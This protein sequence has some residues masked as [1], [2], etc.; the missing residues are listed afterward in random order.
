MNAAIAIGLIGVA[1]CAC[2]FAAAIGAA[3]AR[4]LFSLTMFVAAAGALAAAALVALGAGEAGL[5]QALFGL[6]LAPM[7]LLACLLLSTRAAK[8][9]RHGMPWLTI[10]AALGAVGAAIWALP[11]LG[12]IPAPP[13][14][15]MARFDLPL[16][17]SLAALV[18]VAVAGA[19]SLLAYGERGALQRVA[20][21]R[22]E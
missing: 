9:R 17:A 13:I 4:S 8:P 1:L 21:E 14:R 19:A 5:A 10:A 7:V 22:D 3:M 2:V 12:A 11:E 16:M 15:A 6:G 18:F 20:L